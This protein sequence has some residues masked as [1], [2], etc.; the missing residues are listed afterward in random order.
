MSARIEIDVEEFS[1]VWKEKTEAF[2]AAMRRA[3]EEA[4]ASIKSEMETRAPTRTGALKSSIKAVV[5]ETKAIVG[6][7][8]SYAP[9]VEYGTRPSPGRYVPSIAKRLVNP[10]LPHFGM[11]PGIRPTHFVEEAALASEPRIEAIFDSI[12]QEALE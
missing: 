1:R 7:T 11:H 8:V 4:A 2:K 6:P 10:S 12:M 5:E 3:L 9:Y